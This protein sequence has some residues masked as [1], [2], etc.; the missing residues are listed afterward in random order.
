MLK[1]NML[2]FLWQRVFC[3]ALSCPFD[4]A[5][6]QLISPF[7]DQS[8]FTENLLQ[9]T[10]AIQRD[11]IQGQEFSCIMLNLLPSRDAMRN[12]EKVFS[13]P[14]AILQCKN[15]RMVNNL[16]WVT[17]VIH[18][19]NICLVPNLW[20]DMFREI[21]MF[22]SVSFSLAFYLSDLCSFFVQ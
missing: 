5:I 8:Q 16:L 22:K 9:T 13:N 10:F 3:Y 15:K 14:A 7:T 1:P 17:C 19:Q 18:I 21:K 6:H 12:R 4:L 20:T 11:A 2:A